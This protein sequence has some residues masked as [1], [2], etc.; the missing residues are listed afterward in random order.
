MLCL[1][2]ATRPAWARSAIADVDLLVL[3]HAHC[4][5]KAAANAL[6]L[7]GRAP[8]R[9]AKALTDLAREEIDH[10]QEVLAWLERRGVTLGPP[11]KDLYAAALRRAP[12]ELEPTTMAPLVD[13]LLVACLIE[14]RS[15]ERFK[16]LTAELSADPARAELAELYGRL[17]AAEARHYRTLLDLAVLAADDDSDRVMSR[18]KKLAEVEG[19]IVSGLPPD[20]QPPTIHG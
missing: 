18:L 15:C 10:F 5:M 14:A 19:R 7:A 1:T 9:V 11:S 3:D 4:E 6:S 8:A 12:L 2:V 17:T 16:L 20:A 13:R